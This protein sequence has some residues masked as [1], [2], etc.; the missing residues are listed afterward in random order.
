M[1]TRRRPF[2]SFGVLLAALATGTTA[3]P[4]DGV[5][6][7]P[8]Q[9]APEMTVGP[10]TDLVDGQQ[11]TVTGAGFG[12]R[13]ALTIYQCAVSDFVGVVNCDFGT[14]HEVRAAADGSVSTR[15]PVYA[16]IDTWDREGVD[17]RDP[18]TCMLATDVSFQEVGTA[19]TAHIAF[20]PGAAEQL[21]TVTA[22]VDEGMVDRQEVRVEG[23]GFVRSERPLVRVYQCGTHPELGTGCRGGPSQTAELDGDGR[24]TSDVVVSTRISVMA[25]GGLVDCRS[26]AAGCYIEVVAAGRNRTVRTA[27]RSGLDFDPDAAIPDWPRPELTVT[28]TTDLD[29]MDTVAVHGTG[30]TPGGPVEIW[31][32][33]PEGIE[34]CLWRIVVP[35]AD[36]RGTVDAEVSV[37]ATIEALEP[38]G[39]PGPL[40]C[41]QAPGCVLIARDLETGVELTTL[42]SFRDP[43]P[44]VRYRD[45]VFDEV[46]VIRDVVYRETT[47]SRGNPVELKLDIYLPR[48][49]TVTRRPATVWMHGGFFRGGSK[50]SMGPYA[51]ASAR[52]GQVGVSL[53]YRLRPDAERWQDMYL[54][55]LDAYDDAT[56]AVA[57]LQQHADQYGIDPDAIVAGGFSAGA[58]NALN[59]AYLPGQRGPATSLIAAA[60]PES[61]LLYTPPEEGE[62]PT[63]AFHGTVDS[64][65]HYDN[66]A[67]LCPQAAL[68]DVPC[69]LVTYEGMGHGA[70]REDDIVW[71]SSAFVAENVL[72]PLGYF[73][74]T[75]DAGGPYEVD[76]GSTVALDATASAGDDLTY[77]WS[78]A[79]RLDDPHAAR[80][81][82]TGLDDGAETLGL[83]VTSGHGVR[84]QTE[85][86]LTTTNVDPSIETMSLPGGA[87]TRTVAF[88]A[89]VTD[90]GLLDTHTATVDWGDGTVEPV[91]V[92]PV[93]GEQAAGSATARGDHT[94][95]TVGEYE[96]TLTVTDDDGGTDERTTRTVVGCT[97]SGTA[98]DDRL[99]GTAG[100]D[101]ICGLGGDDLL[102]GGRGDDVL[103]GGPGGDRLHGGPGADRL[104]G[105]PDRDRADG[106]PGR[107]QCMAERRRSCR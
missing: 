85:T 78:P 8:A 64:V 42:L 51:T 62:P 37:Q 69:E 84:G 46:D 40:D 47:D 77:S 29:D 6:A 89:S 101:V 70:G 19:V 80:P 41:R 83:T 99:T 97:M 79:D 58:V 30:F 68:V 74:V 96:V 50:Y 60:I 10:S 9:T 53:Q 104:V 54:A 32:C 7:A 45:P 21:P 100:D 102:R 88:E 92:E 15:M 1:A 5:R 44:G 13:Q 59:L 90:P 25:G 36:G 73:A 31:Q 105:G 67:T 61:G 56:A 66:V 76:E 48:G 107:D 20:D 14:A 103:L 11:V 23:W 27:A 17:C 71:R 86:Q 3:V 22:S 91:A 98:D 18:G 16:V 4:A 34:P 39:A 43:E 72:G 63:I 94:Y 65:L 49:D 93:A 12:S 81:G 24:F 33:P 28:P 2:L 106:G 57:W 95:A 35:S 82:V 75:A 52:H 87:T 26:D 55:S 38:S